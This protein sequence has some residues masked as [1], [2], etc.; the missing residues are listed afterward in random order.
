MVIWFPCIPSLPSLASPIT[1][2]DIST[3]CFITLALLVQS[4]NTQTY[5][6]GTDYVGKAEFL[7]ER[8]DLYFILSKHP[9]EGVRNPIQRLRINP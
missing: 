9:A 7:P 8:I 4:V 6:S 1:A 5:F 3:T 2:E